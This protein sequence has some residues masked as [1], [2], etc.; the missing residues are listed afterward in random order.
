MFKQRF[1]RFE[2]KAFLDFLPANVFSPSSQASLHNPKSK[3]ISLGSR[4]VR[5]SDQS[6]ETFSDTR[7]HDTSLPNEISIDF[8]NQ[9]IT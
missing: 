5:E 9:I 7:L 1:L 2:S 3:L 8:G 4:R 6:T